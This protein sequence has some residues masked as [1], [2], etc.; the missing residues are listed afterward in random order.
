MEKSNENT[1][2]TISVTRFE[3]VIVKADTKTPNGFYFLSN[4]DH[5]EAVIMQTVYLYKLHESEKKCSESAPHVIRNA[6]AKVLVHYYPLSG[7]LKNGPDGK[8]GVDCVDKGVLFVEALADCNIALLGDVTIPDYTVLGKLVYV[9]P[10]AENITDVPLMTAQ[11]TRFKGGDFVLGLT[12]NH[13][14]ADG[15]AA[16]E[17]INSW[18]ETARGLPL[19]SPPF[20]D[21][22]LIKSRQPPQRDHPIE[23]TNIIDISNMERLYQEE[24]LL[25]KSFQFDAEKLAKLKKIAIEDGS[26]VKTCTSFTVLAAFLWRARSRALKM[27]SNQ[28]VRLLITVDIRARLKDQQLPK[29]YFGN[30]TIVAECHCLA[31]EL[32]EK[33]FPYVV[34]MVQSSVQGVDSESVQSYI[35]YFEKDRPIPCL[36]ATLLITS[37]TRIPFNTAN[38]GWGDATQFGTCMLPREIALFSPYGGEKKGVSVVLGLPVSA[39]NSLQE[40]IQV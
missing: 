3:P 35:D 8:L 34:K 24:K 23:F 2:A 10:G 26:V 14:M 5:H 13:A 1:H 20:L 4:L 32:I 21:R 9:F 12:L 28:E 30:A 33:P 27:N 38:F 17:F 7:R 37:W 39:M 31:G 18:G 11:V 29:G 22:T 19:T 25:I 40:F 36:T 16:M 6:L 15:I